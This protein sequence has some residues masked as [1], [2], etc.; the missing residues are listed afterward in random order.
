MELSVTSRRPEYAFQAR[1]TGLISQIEVS[2]V[3]GK[4]PLN[5]I[6]HFFNQIWNRTFQPNKG[7]D[8][9]ASSMLGLARTRNNTILLVGT[10]L[11]WYLYI[12][13]SN[14]DHNLFQWKHVC[15]ETFVAL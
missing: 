11:F 4:G 1:L 2:T 12:F 7:C 13:M 3:F 6:S 14:V 5:S 10:P 8:T 15:F 9:I